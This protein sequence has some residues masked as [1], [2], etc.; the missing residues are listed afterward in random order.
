ME[1][2]E[3]H[4]DM[5]IGEIKDNVDFFIRDGLAVVQ[6]NQQ[7]LELVKLRG[8]RFFKSLRARKVSKACAQEDRLCTSGMRALLLS[9]GSDLIGVQGADL[10]LVTSVDVKL[11]KDDV[12]FGLGVYVSFP[13][14]DRGFEFASADLFRV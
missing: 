1:R 9:T 14:C 7:R 4:L 11:V 13:H 6:L 3:R 5:T 10:E 2:A 8:A 12:D